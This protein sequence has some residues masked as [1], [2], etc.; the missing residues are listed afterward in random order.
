M[1]RKFGN[2]DFEVTTLALGGQA[3]LQWTPAD[4]D[5]VPIILKAF[6]LGINYFD[7]SNLYAESQLNYNKAFK[8]L[9]LIP[10]EASYDEKLRKSIWLT[11]KTCMRWGKP[12]WPERE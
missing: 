6:K 10:G 1:K 2:F 7:T 11:S 4:V 12:G 8:I 5:P 3:S 9:N